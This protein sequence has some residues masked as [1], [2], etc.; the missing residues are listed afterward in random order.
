MCLSYDLSKK[1]TII[2]PVSLN[3]AITL[4]FDSFFI[5]NRAMKNLGTTRITNKE[6]TWKLKNDSLKTG[7]SKIKTSLHSY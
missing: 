4:E 2:L 3:N 7:Q 1:N 6:N 5:E